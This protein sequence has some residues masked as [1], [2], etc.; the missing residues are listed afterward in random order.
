MT[1]T[2]IAAFPYP[3][4]YGPDGCGIEQGTYGMSLRDYFA[5]QALSGIMA[6]TGSYGFNNG[7]GEI[8]KRS[9]EL[10]DA[11]LKARL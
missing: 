4:V 5:A 10:A 6:F 2:S 3:S 9:Y 11:M 8:S 7:P 1:D